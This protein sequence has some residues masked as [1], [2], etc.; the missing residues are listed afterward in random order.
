MFDLIT[1]LK[2]PVA[3]MGRDLGEFIRSDR[4]M[5]KRIDVGHEDYFV[6]CLKNICF[7]SDGKTY[8]STILQK[9]HTIIALPPE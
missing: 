1:P 8:Y 6:S 4:S 5:K 3:C 9:Y 7:E 2:N